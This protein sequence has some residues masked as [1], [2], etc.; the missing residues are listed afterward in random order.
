MKRRIF[1]CDTARALLFFLLYTENLT[2]R[3]IFIIGQ[4]IDPELVKRLTGP[5][6]QRGII[7][8]ELYKRNCS[9]E[10]LAKINRRL[11]KIKRAVDRGELQ[12]YGLGHTFWTNYVFD[13]QP[14]HLIEDGLSNALH[15]KFKTEPKDWKSWRK[16]CSRRW[17]RWLQ[18]L[19]GK[20]QHRREPFGGDEAVDQAKFICSRELARYM[21]LAPEAAEQ[22]DL[23]LLWDAKPPEEKAYINRVFQ[24]DPAA[25]PETAE[26]Y[27]LL[28]T[29]PLSEDGILSEAEKIRL[30]RKIIAAYPGEKILLKPHPR[31]KTDYRAFF[32]EVQVWQGNYPWELAAVQGIKIKIGATMFSTAI[33]MLGPEVRKDIYG[34]MGEE[35]I[36]KYFG[37]DVEGLLPITAKLKEQN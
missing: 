9:K 6:I 29:Q 20:P 24:L 30:Y 11:K 2:G 15:Y 22:V 32:P 37:P 19:R 3:H 16:Y 34:V 10:R 14:L 1:I 21:K 33:L 18:K 25:L 8:E 27:V 12:L 36:L 23:Q 13:T 31:E 4:D 35:K 7:P 5:K 17:R 26:A 28:F